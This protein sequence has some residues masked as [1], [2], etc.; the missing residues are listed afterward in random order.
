MEARR[1]LTQ[2]NK[3][4]LNALDLSGSPVTPQLTPKTRNNT[5]STLRNSGQKSILTVSSLIK[6]PQS[7]QYMS[8]GQHQ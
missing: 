8:M 7:N 1:K 4:L 5:R 6:T 2:T 3:N